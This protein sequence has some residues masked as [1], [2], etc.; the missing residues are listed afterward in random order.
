MTDCSPEEVRAVTESPEFLRA[1]VAASA[2]VPADEL[3][4]ACLRHVSAVR[5]HD[6]PSLV[7]AGK[8][9]AALLRDNPNRLTALLARLEP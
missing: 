5:G 7:R 4:V 8:R 3:I 1:L 2:E 9:L 6:Y